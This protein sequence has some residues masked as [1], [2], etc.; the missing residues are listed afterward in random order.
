MTKVAKKYVC[1]I[2]AAVFLLSIVILSISVTLALHYDA[3]RSTTT[4]EMT[5]GVKLEVGNLAG[6]DGSRLLKTSG[7]TDG[8]AYPGTVISVEAPTIMLKD[9]SLD[10]YARFTLELQYFKPASSTVSLSQTQISNRFTFVCTTNAN[11]T[12]ASQIYSYANASTSNT[13]KA[14]ATYRT[15]AWTS[16]TITV[17]SALTAAD[18]EDSR[19]VLVMK[20]G[21]VQKSNY[22]PVQAW[23]MFNLAATY[24]NL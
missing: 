1:I 7:L 4:I 9:A 5:K 17:N 14:G 6:I 10:S 13:L 8:E 22:T 24:I 2:L 16:L 12:Y 11:W 15:S 21:A 23:Q 18:L 19:L 20:I 3:R